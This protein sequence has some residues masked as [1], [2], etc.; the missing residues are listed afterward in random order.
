MRGRIVTTAHA[1][2]I[3]RIAARGALTHDEAGRHGNTR[4]NGVLPYAHCA[5]HRVR[6]CGRLLDAKFFGIGK[7]Q[8]SG[9]NRPYDDRAGP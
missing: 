8:I 7:Y 6:R 5:D 9:I 2:Q 4:S 3:H 1:P